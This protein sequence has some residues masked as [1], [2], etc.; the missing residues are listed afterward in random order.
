MRPDTVVCWRWA[1][2]PGYRSAFGP[3]TVNTLRAM[4]ARWYPSLKRF[5]CVTDSA[6]GIDPRV[7]VVPLWEEFGALPSPHGGNNPSCYRRL[8]MFHPDAAQW[9]GKR[10]VSLDLDCVV[11]GDLTPLWDRP[12]DV[13]LYGDT[14]PRTHYN[15]SM[16]LVAAGSRP[17]VW[18]EFDPCMSPQKA[19]TAGF[20][21]SDQAWLSYILGGKEAKWTRRDGV[22][23]FRNELSAQKSLPA[24]ARIV[25][26]HGHTDPWASYAQLNYPWV[27]E[28]YRAEVAA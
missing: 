17:M 12:E 8:R 21:G 16:M 20:W 24:D 13:V 19:R 14:N 15:G 5:I 26:F 27:R 25:I 4:V 11:T 3:E 22:Y 18:N 10:F 1:P 23:S 7:E 2:I 9:F 6:A 28:H